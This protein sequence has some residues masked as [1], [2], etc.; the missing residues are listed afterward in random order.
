MDSSSTSQFLAGGGQMGDRMRRHTWAQTAIGTPDHWPQSLRT[1]VSICLNSRFPMILWWGPDLTIL[2]NDPYIPILGRKHPDWALGRPGRDCWAEAWDVIG[3]LLTR[4]MEAGEANWADDLVLFINRSGYLEECYFQFSYSPIRDES[5]GIAGVFTPVS[6]TTEKVL[7]ERRLKTLRDLASAGYQARDPVNACTSLAR[8]LEANPHDVPFAAIYLFDPQRRTARLTATAGIAAGT[9]VSP[10]EIPQDAPTT[11]LELACAAMVRMHLDS[12][13]VQAPEGG[14]W[15]AIPSSILVIPLRLPGDTAVTGWLVAGASARKLLDGR[16]ADFFDLITQQLSAALATALVAET[17]RKRAEALA[18]LDRAKTAFFSNV[19]HEFRTPL[20][21]LMGPLEEGLRDPHTP[22]QLREQLKLARRNSMRLLKLVNSLLDFNRVEAGRHQ[23]RFEPLDLGTLTRDV[24]STFESVMRQGG[25]ELVVD[26]ESLTEPVYADREMWETIVLNLLSNAFKYTFNG[27]I[28]VRLGLTAADVELDVAD[29]GVGIAAEHIPK[30]LTRFY[31]VPGAAGRSHEGSGIGLSL[32]QEFVHQQGGTLTIESTPGFG[33]VFTVRLP[34]KHASVPGGWHD[35]IKPEADHSRVNAF[36]AEATRWLS[37]P[38]IALMPASDDEAQGPSV[39]PRATILLADDNADMRDYLGR[40]LSRRF[41]VI[42]APD[43]AEALDLAREQRPDLVL[44]DVMMPGLD[45][46]GLLA[47]LRSEE[48]TRT[49]PVILLSA[50][51]GEEAR[52]EGLGAGA[53]DYLV[54][55]FSARELIARIESH[56]TLTRTRDEARVALEAAVTETKRRAREAEETNALLATILEERNR[57]VEDLREAQARVQA[58]MA[59]AEVGA[60]VWKLKENRIIGDLN[61]ARLYGFTPEQTLNSSSEVHMAHIH[62]ADHQ[63]LRTAI[64]KALV[65]GTLTV[66]EY[67]VGKSENSMRWVMGRGTVQYDPQGEPETMSGLVIDIEDRKAME[68]ALRTADRQK[69]RF[70]ATLS[71]ELRNPL[72]PIRNAAQLLSRPTLSTDQLA[73]ARQVIQRQVKHMAWLLDDLLDVAR[74]T[75][76]K[77]ELKRDRVTLTSIVDAAVEAV[78]P[79]LDAKQH[80][81]T[82]TLPDAD[83]VLWVDP[84]RLAQVMSNLLNNAAKYTDAGGEVALVAQVDAMELSLSVTDNGIGIPETMLTRIFTMFSQVDGNAGRS[85]GGL[86]IGL[87]L[88][89]GLVELHGGTIRARSAGA[90]QGSTFEAKLPRA[91]MRAPTADA[92]AEALPAAPAGGR[93]ILIADDNRDAAESLAMLL[94]MSGHEVRVAHSGCDALSLAQ[95]FRP[96]VAL[97]DIGMPDLTGYD[98]ARSL[99]KTPWGQD[100]FLVA[101]TGWGQAADKQHAHDAGF[102]HHITKPV[103][104]EHLDALVLGVRASR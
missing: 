38:D 5:G 74:I 23:A 66:P 40:L 41:K 27:R 84:L 19:S 98:V 55:P 62:P 35:D 91:I 95:V 77:L 51:A 49:L 65:T 44:A 2:Y 70:L 22:P 75:Q 15:Q 73:W 7:A 67:R 102:N 17:E 33:S 89:K 3:P 31:R 79:L 14:P 76:G 99:R 63:T 1:A 47:A 97:V 37:G 11:E 45:G 56:L 48:Q 53:D 26:C 42:A 9:P 90:G 68:E 60:W 13:I 50:R 24:A 83:P 28:S 87:A 21:L 36:V 59:A 92:P 80:R 54:K 12:H 94:E 93:R 78:R 88:V 61:M 16:Y 86:G 4:V 96:T 43:G 104:P 20:T 72:A 57:A 82:L 85:E 30:L 8:V 29:T 18:E 103:D 34:L 100:V 69:D 6:E 71:H 39:A 101:L 46:F 64:E 25:L 81:L 52:I 32:V 58:T 10:I